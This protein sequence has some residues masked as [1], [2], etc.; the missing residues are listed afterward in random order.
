MFQN[1]GKATK[2]VWVAGL[3]ACSDTLR[4]Y[5]GPTD[6]SIPIDDGET[7]NVS[8]DAVEPARATR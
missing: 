4:T 7:V 6:V 3:D 8:P 1:G 5:V 2:I